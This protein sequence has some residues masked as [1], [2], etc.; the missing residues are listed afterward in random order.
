MADVAKI[1]S[2]LAQKDE[3]P[4]L[5]FKLKYVMS[6]AG[7]S[8]HKDEQ[9]QEVRG[10]VE[11]LATELYKEDTI[12][13]MK[14]DSVEAEAL[15]L[16]QSHP[17]D[18]VLMAIEGM[19]RSQIAQKMHFINFVFGHFFKDVGLH[20]VKGLAKLTEVDLIDL[21]IKFAKDNKDIK[22]NMYFHTGSQDTVS[23][24][25]LNNKIVDGIIAADE[26]NR[27]LITRQSRSGEGHLSLIERIELGYDIKRN[28]MPLASVA[29]E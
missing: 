29:V 5:E 18:S 14:R 28:S 9:G 7:S 21:G 10:F 24:P 1:R 27:G 15:N 19:D 12:D 4:R 6:G 23:P 2:W 20:Y 17:F 26:S 3:T 25:Y 8:K 16:Y 11:R 22:R 13:L